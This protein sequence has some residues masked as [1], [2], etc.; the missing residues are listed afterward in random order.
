MKGLLFTELLEM[1]EEDFGYN[2]ASSIVVRSSLSSKGIYTTARTYHR[3]E[4]NVLFQQLHQ[5]TKLPFDHLTQAFGRH[6]CKKMLIAYP[7]HRAYINRIFVFI[8]KRKTVPV[9][10]F[11]GADKKTLTIL[12]AP[13]LKTNC[14]T[15]GVI[16][17]YVGYL[18][19]L[20][21]AQE[22]VLPDGR[23]KFVLSLNQ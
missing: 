6:L 4:M 16:Q 3:N 10:E 21:R 23:R 17:G 9:F 7:Q 1:V 11:L 22:S 15:E 12:F 19:L 14:V 18:Q 13:Q 20:N 5:Q 8:T 2:T